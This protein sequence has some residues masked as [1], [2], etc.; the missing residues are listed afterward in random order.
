MCTSAVSVETGFTVNYS[1]QKE[2]C[3]L[4]GSFHWDGK[5]VVFPQ[6]NRFSFSAWDVFVRL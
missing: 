4:R 5:P 6:V 1:L 2:Q 3:K